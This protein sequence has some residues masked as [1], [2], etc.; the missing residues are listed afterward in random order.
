MLHQP[1]AP[2]GK[3]PSSAFKARLGV[4]MFVVYALFYA[5]F[6]AVNITNPLAMERTVFAGLNLAVVYGMSL[7]L[8][9]LLLALVYDRICSV[10][11][12]LLAKGGKN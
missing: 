10:R 3:D 9:A 11:E 8:V 4:W 2:S 7:I 6:V 5:G 1:A 12:R